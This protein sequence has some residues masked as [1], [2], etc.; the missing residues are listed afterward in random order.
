[1]NFTGHASCPSSC[2]A[3]AALSE[4]RASPFLALLP[5][6][7]DAGLPSHI[8]PEPG[9]LIGGCSLW[10]CLGGSLAW[11]HRLQQRRLLRASLCHT[12]LS[13][14]H[15]SV[16]PTRG[17]GVQE[18]PLASE[19]GVHGSSTSVLGHHPLQ[20]CLCLCHEYI[21]FHQLH[22][23]PAFHLMQHGTDSPWMTRGRCRLTPTCVWLRVVSPAPSAPTS[24]RE[25]GSRQWDG[26]AIALGH[27]GHPF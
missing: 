13:L 24:P 6:E 4:D 10:L 22:M 20:P 5:S 12:M 27:Q 25:D 21:K 9:T 23:L 2:S 3:Q 18:G 14:S 11:T 16:C 8:G 17:G 1:M 7:A 26:R 19:G 15:I